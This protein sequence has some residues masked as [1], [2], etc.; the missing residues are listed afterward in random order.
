MTIC[1]EGCFG[2]GY[3]L[4]SFLF[5]FFKY[6]SV[7]NQVP[8]EAAPEMELGYLVRSSPGLCGCG[9]EGRKQYQTK[10]E[11]G[12]PCRPSVSL[13]GTLD[14][15]DSSEYPERALPCPLPC[16]STIG[17]PPP[18]PNNWTGLWMRWLFAAD[19]V[20]KGLH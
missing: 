16:R 2:L 8:Q 10:G 3:L 7:L 19:T 14:S 11:A 15:D 12:F 9:G 18:H 1:S 13:R 20:I 6:G 17:V 4:V 5:Y